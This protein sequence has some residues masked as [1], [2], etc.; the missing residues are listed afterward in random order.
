MQIW[1]CK[2]PFLE[3][4]HIQIAFITFV[5]VDQML[6]WSARRDLGLL[7]VSKKY[8]YHEIGVDSPV[9]L[10]D[11]KLNSYMHSKLYAYITEF[12]IKSQS[13][14]SIKTIHCDYQIAN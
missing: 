9:S 2:I 1:W 3:W 5:Y 6:I 10:L 4:T 13:V 14:N 7:Y 8:A 12:F 11:F